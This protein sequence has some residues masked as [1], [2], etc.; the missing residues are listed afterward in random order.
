MHP[1]IPIG[2]QENLAAIAKVKL[3]MSEIACCLVFEAHPVSDGGATLKYLVAKIGGATIGRWICA[4]SRPPGEYAGSA[5]FTFVGI[6]Y[7]I[8]AADGCKHRWTKCVAN[9]WEFLEATGFEN[10]QF[11]LHFGLATQSSS[12]EDGLVGHFKRVRACFGQLVAQIGVGTKYFTGF[13]VGP[14]DLSHVAMRSFLLK[15]FPFHLFIDG[16]DFQSVATIDDGR[17]LGV[18]V[19]GREGQGKNE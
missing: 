13:G 3:D 15:K 1:A 9:S 17:S 11:L 5:G 18:K 4:F 16:R 2:G 7:A 8:T 10:D 12:G 6:G 14:G 19:V